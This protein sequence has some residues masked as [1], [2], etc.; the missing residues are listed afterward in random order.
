MVITG[1]STNVVIMLLGS[2]SL[3]SHDREF[4]TPRLEPE[5][6]E[7]NLVLVSVIWELG[8]LSRSRE[9]FVAAQY[10]NR[11]GAKRF[12]TTASIDGEHHAGA[13]LGGAAHRSIS[14]F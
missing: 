11:P 6:F 14:G 3:A 1:R 8:T 7:M 10:M 2:V 4:E 13:Q 12:R 5:A 9:G